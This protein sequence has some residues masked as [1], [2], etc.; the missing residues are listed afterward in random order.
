MVS[1]DDEI[2]S[3]VVF[4]FAICYFNCMVIF[5]EAVIIALNDRILRPKVT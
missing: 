3:K 2:A 1:L 4:T 5:S